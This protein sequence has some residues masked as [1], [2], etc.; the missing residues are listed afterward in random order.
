MLIFVTKY[1]MKYILILLF[2][3]WFS[4]CD[5]VEDKSLFSEEDKSFLEWDFLENK[6]W[7]DYILDE[8]WDNIDKDL[9]IW[10][11]FFEW[12]ELEIED[13]TLWASILNWVSM[14]WNYFN[15]TN[16]IDLHKVTWSIDFWE[17][18]ISTWALVWKTLNPAYWDKINWL[19]IAFANSNISWIFDSISFWWY[20]MENISVSN[21]KTQ[22]DIYF[23]WKEASWRSLVLKKIFT[24]NEN[25]LTQAKLSQD[26]KVWKKYVSAKIH[27]KVVSQVAENEDWGLLFN[28]PCLASDFTFIEDDFKNSSEVFSSDFYEKNIWT[29]YLLSDFVSNPELARTSSWINL[30]LNWIPWLWNWN[31]KW[32]WLCVFNDTYNFVKSGAVWSQCWEWESKKDVWRLVLRPHKDSFCTQAASI[33]E[34]LNYPEYACNIAISKKWILADIQKYFWW[35]KFDLEWENYTCWE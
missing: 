26:K 8:K 7:K 14:D 18:V 25:F 30:S 1:F 22:F 31:V 17:W 5:K 3:F 20:W 9:N 19:K 28:W 32:A 2:I 29:W 6:S 4:S 10:D 23:D 15:E 33:K 12:V 21:W 16:W 24:S 11:D 13:D 27:T 35:D 34:E